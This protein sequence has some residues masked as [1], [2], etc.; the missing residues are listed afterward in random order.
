MRRSW[1]RLFWAGVFICAVIVGYLAISGVGD[2]LLHQEIE[3]QLGRL[4]AGHVEI[5]RVEVR[6]EDGLLIEAH[7]FE[8]YPRPEG[9]MPALRASRVLAWVD[10]LAILVGRLELS[11]LILE[12]PQ[13]RIEQRAD[14]S[15]IGL[16][17]P[18]STG[19]NK[20][21]K[22][23]SVA[24]NA[25]RQLAALEPSANHFLETFRAADRISVIDGSLTLIDHTSQNEDGTPRELRF[26]LLTGGA[27]RNWLTGA[28]TLDWRGVFVDGQH[29][30]FPFKFRVERDPSSNFEWTAAVS[31]VPLEAANTPLSFID[32]RGELAGTLD[33]ECVMT[34]I[35][36]GT[37]RL[38]FTGT[39]QNAAVR[40]PRSGALIE[41]DRVEIQVETEINARRLRVSKAR[42]AGERLGFDFKGAIARPIRAGSMTRIESRMVGVQIDGI[43]DLAKRFEDEF[44]IALAISRLTES[45]QA[46]HVRYLEAAGSARLQRWLDLA[47]GKTRELPDGFLFGGGIDQVVFEVG[48]GE[49]VED[50]SGEIEW[51]EDRISLRD[52][53]GRYRDES[54]PT[55]NATLDGISNLIRTATSMDRVQTAPPAI[56]GVAPLLA[57]FKPRDPDALPPVRAIGLAIGRLDHPIFRYSL[58]DLRVLIEPS[59]NAITMKVR[60]GTWGGA[61]VEGDIAWFADSKSPT[62]DAHLTLGPAPIEMPDGD[63]GALAVVPES[64]WGSGL[65]ELQF[66]PRPTLP[67]Q[68]ATGFF[69]LD[70]AD[71]IG[72]E[73]E[74][75]LEPR[76][77]AA[78][79]TKIDLRDPE[80]IGLDLSFA[81]TDATLEGMSEF[82]ALPPD[83][84]AGDIGAT[85]TLMGRV[86]PDDSFIAELD[87]SVQIDAKNGLIRTNL[88][89]LLRLG[90]A[91]EGYNPFA[92]A[93]ELSYEAMS[94]TL[95]INHGHLRME[96]F[97]LEGP[98]RVYANVRLDTN[99]SPGRIRAVVGI[100]LFRTPNQIFSS[101][102]LLKSFLPGSDR[103]LIGAYFKV[104]GPLDE[105]DVDA[106][107]LK[108][109]MSSVPDAIKAPFTAMRFLFGINEDE[110]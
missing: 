66:R 72:H 18:S 97:E 85:G 49:F 37:H 45:V 53:N 57:I 1:L 2:R 76:G 6:F 7:G 14:G 74:I 25:L 17:I 88:P 101:I 68:T 70:D 31:K 33:A 63:E 84:A 54:L 46:G 64:R 15:F 52:M 87:G 62:V 75:R 109:L 5:A 81:I 40:L 43:R 99:Q 92:N 12:G 8:A 60:E 26:E 20:K 11:T 47:N 61:T 38:T 10:M 51:V 98:L 3:T 103:G 34:T 9:D 41:Q 80:T 107:A 65:F 100:F 42:I 21:T 110:P 79:R 36:P 27:A 108:T 82:V 59:R 106:L 23:S 69:R 19:P 93:D 71:L 16:P 89:L 30:P 104:K 24:E 67:F 58:R 28:A 22:A 35:A 90:K 29:T 96:N 95:K 94:G 50:L 32:S 78:I 77:G 73:V 55:M 44:E 39:V 91:T 13:I 4:L 105:P 56:P 102:P 83:L 48:G 86:R